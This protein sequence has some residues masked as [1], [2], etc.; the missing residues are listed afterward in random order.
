MQSWQDPY[1]NHMSAFI[2]VASV[3]W[4]EFGE[5]CQDLCFVWWLEF[6]DAYHDL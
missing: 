4:L 1:L 3:L 2:D 6:G 5:A